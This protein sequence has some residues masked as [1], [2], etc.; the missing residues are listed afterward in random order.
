MSVAS[1][2]KNVHLVRRPF[3]FCCCCCSSSSGSTGIISAVA[4]SVSLL[5]DVVVVVVVVVVV[6]GPDDASSSVV[7]R[8]PTVSLLGE[9]GV[10]IVALSFDTDSLAEKFSQSAVMVSPSAASKSVIVSFP[11]PQSKESAPP[12]SVNVSSPLS[13]KNS[14][15]RPSEDPTS[16]SSPLPP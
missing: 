1:S 7:G 4:A 11:G 3:W 2:I 16:V 12:R 6:G 10:P 9:E 15:S 8:F 13:P 5:L 14:S